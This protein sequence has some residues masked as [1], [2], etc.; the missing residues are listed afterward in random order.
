MVALGRPRPR[1]A[2]LELASPGGFFII[3]FGVGALVVGLLTLAGVGGPALAPVAALHGRLVGLA[4]ARSSAIRCCAACAPRRSTT[5]S[6]A[7]TSDVAIAID[8]IAPG[9]VGRAELRGTAWSA[10]NVGAAAVHRG[11]RCAVRK[12]DGLMLH[13]VAEGAL[14][15]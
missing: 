4:A 15:A 11:Q 8:D 9:A 3:F 13:I 10:R 14:T 2:A 5:P 12:V 1:P 7:L 6:T